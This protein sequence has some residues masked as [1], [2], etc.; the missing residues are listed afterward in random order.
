MATQQRWSGMAF[1]V[2]LAFQDA[3]SNGG[4]QK[5]ARVNGKER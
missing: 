3:I 5:G 1:V 2:V 4:I